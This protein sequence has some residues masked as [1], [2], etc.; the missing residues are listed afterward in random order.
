MSTCHHETLAKNEV[1]HVQR[2]SHCGGIT[3]HLGP[4]SFRLDERALFA[5]LGVLGEAHGQLQQ[6]RGWS[7]RDQRRG[8][9]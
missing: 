2:C 6:A 7:G 3:V 5:L 1:A 9:A 4:F 8:L